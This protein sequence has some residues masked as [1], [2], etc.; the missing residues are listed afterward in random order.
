MFRLTACSSRIYAFV[1]LRSTTRNIPVYRHFTEVCPILLYGKLLHLLVDQP[2]FFFR[3]VKLHLYI[4]LSVSISAP[5]FG[6]RVWDYPN[7]HFSQTGTRLL[8]LLSTPYPFQ[9]QRLL[10]SLSNLAQKDC[11]PYALQSPASHIVRLVL[12]L[13]DFC[14]LPCRC[15]YN[16]YAFIA[17]TVQ[18]RVE[19]PPPG[20]FLRIAVREEKL[21]YRNMIP[22]YKVIEYL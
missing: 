11:S 4:S 22:G 12:C 10:H 18:Q 8:C 7:K 20:G 2:L 21:I 9:R 13:F 19:L 17:H 5:P 1:S 6:I 15:G 14:Y 16:P 3:N